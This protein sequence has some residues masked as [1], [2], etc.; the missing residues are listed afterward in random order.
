MP[1]RKFDK[2]LRVTEMEMTI[3]PKNEWKQIFTDAWRFERDFFYDKICTAWIGMQCVNNMV[4]F[5]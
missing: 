5:G 3:N 1:I 2:T 4:L